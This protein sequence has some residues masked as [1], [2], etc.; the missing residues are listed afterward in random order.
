[1]ECN[2]LGRSGLKVQL[3]LI[4]FYTVCKAEQ[5]VVG[6]ELDVRSDAHRDDDDD[7]E[8]ENVGDEFVDDRGDEVA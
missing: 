3:R 2:L 7:D 6:M 8:L 5:S 4:F 1:M